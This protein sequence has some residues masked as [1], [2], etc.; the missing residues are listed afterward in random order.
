MS[1]VDFIKL[2]FYNSA[3]DER[4]EKNTLEFRTGRTHFLNIKFSWSK[5]KEANTN[6]TNQMNE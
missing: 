1:L 6:M 2:G 5:I 4:Q 3:K